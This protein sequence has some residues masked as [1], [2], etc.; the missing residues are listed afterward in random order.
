MLRGN[1]YAGTEEQWYQKHLE[2]LRE[3][4]IMKLIDTPMMLELRGNMFIMLMR[5]I[6]TH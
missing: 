5:M 4:G 2:A 3:K 1:T 6:P